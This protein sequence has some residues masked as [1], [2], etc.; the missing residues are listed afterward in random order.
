MSTLDM[1]DINHRMKRQNVEFDAMAYLA[2]A[3]QALRVTAVVDDDYP[4]VRD[5]YEG[6]VYRFLQAC[7]DNGRPYGMSG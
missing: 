2:K 4:M 5:R 7:K 3:Y 6:A 1:T